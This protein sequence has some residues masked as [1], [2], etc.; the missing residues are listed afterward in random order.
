MFLESAVIGQRLAADWHSDVRDATPEEHGVM[1]EPHG[2]RAVEKAS[3]FQGGI[4]ASKG[5][6]QG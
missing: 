5:R 4:K 1:R 3:T 6:E 2:L